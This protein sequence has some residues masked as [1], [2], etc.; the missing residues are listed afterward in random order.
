[1]G[2]FE[3][4]SIFDRHQQ[5]VTKALLGLQREIELTVCDSGN[6]NLTSYCDTLNDAVTSM[7]N[8]EPTVNEIFSHKF[9]L[10]SAFSAI[11]DRVKDLLAGHEKKLISEDETFNAI[12]ALADI[13]FK[14]RFKFGNDECPTSMSVDESLMLLDHSLKIISEPTRHDFSENFKLLRNMNTILT[15]K[16][17]SIGDLEKIAEVLN[18]VGDD[19]AMQYSESLCSLIARAGVIRPEFLSLVSSKYLLEGILKYIKNRQ[20]SLHVNESAG[21]GL[22]LSESFGDILVT[23][24]DSL[25]AFKHGTEKEKQHAESSLC[26]LIYKFLEDNILRRGDSIY[27]D[28]M[29]DLIKTSWPDLK[30]DKFPMMMHVPFLDGENSKIYFLTDIQWDSF[31]ENHDKISMS[32]TDVYVLPDVH[33]MSNNSLTSAHKLVLASFSDVTEYINIALHSEA[34]IDLLVREDFLEL[35]KS[36]ESQGCL[37]YNLSDGSRIIFFDLSHL[38]RTV[39]FLSLNEYFNN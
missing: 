9:F 6:K 16:D 5:S 31:Q 30:H 22:Q 37:V 13:N 19:T 24:K 23:I 33:S 39:E 32:F 2:Q 15:F 29:L 17:C 36:P 28:V 26:N 20:D 18:R 7:L 21:E 27:G 12:E 8:Y 25:E 34:P 10:K 35:K 11:C 1:M 38:K 3:H 4:L 14:I